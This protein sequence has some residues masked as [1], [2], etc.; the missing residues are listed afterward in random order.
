MSRRDTE[1][2]EE[3]GSLVP[4]PFFQR[5]IMP[6]LALQLVVNPKMASASKWFGKMFTIVMLIGPVRVWRWI[7]AFLFQCLLYVLDFIGW[8]F[9]RPFVKGQNQQPLL[10]Q[11]RITAVR[12]H[13]ELSE[14]V[15]KLSREDIPVASQ[16]VT[17]F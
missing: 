13:V 17:A 5:W 16:S 14:S 10:S 1:I 12:K 11:A 8:H 3:T 9:W 15:K 2:D 7:V 6:G 4:K